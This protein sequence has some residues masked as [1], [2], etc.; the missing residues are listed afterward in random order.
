MSKSFH[1]DKFFWVTAT[2][3]AI[4]NFYL[5]G[6]GPA[7]SLLRADQG[8]SLTV[9]GLHG[10]AM[11]V[12]AIFAGYANPHI[13]H[14]FGRTRAGWIG[15]GIFSIGLTMFVVFPPVVLTLPATLITGFGTSMIINN[16]MTSMSHHYGKAAAVAIPQANGISSV[17]FVLGTGL[18]GGIAVLFPSLWRIGLLIAIPVAVALFLI[19]RSKDVDDHVPDEAGPQRGKLSRRFWISWIGFVACISSEFAVSFWAAA[20]LKDRVGSTAAVSTVALVG[21]GVGMAVGR[22]YGG[23]FLKR[24]TLDTQLLISIAVQFLGFVVFWLSHIMFI[25]AISL[26]II[27]LGVSIQF[28]LASIRLISFSDERPDLAIGQTSLAAGIAIAAAPFLLGVLGDSF[29][30]SRAYIMVPILIAIA[31]A[32]VKFVPSHPEKALLNEL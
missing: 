30:I 9:A 22:W 13:A 28:A 6:F 16:M 14:R 21:L 29:G 4:V 12:A 24:F 15:L 11:G 19:G 25:S 8:T 23:L 7:Q 18:I 26:F 20:L 10:T 2:Q 32:I 17:G 27:G 1:R 31:F 3:T 5:G